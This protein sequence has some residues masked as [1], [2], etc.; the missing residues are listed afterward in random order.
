MAT[1]EDLRDEITRE[2]RV[3]N[4]RADGTVSA[5][6][7]HRRR[8]QMFLLAVVVL[9]GL[10]FTTVANDV[11]TSFRDH[12]WIDPDVARFVLIGFGVISAWYLYD[13]EQHLKR[14]SRLGRD[15]HDLD[16]ALAATMLQ[17]AFVADAT[18]A[19]HSSLDLDDVFERVVEQACR[20]VGAASASLRLAGEDGELV[21]VATQVDI[22]GGALAES[23]PSDDLLRVVGRTQEPALLNSGTVSVLCIPL[24]RDHHLIGL[25]T[26]GAG[27]ADRFNDAD[28]ALLGRFATPAANAIANAQ[29]YEAVVFLLDRGQVGP[30]LRIDEAPDAA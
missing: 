12:S 21:P 14:L 4:L 20:L 11:W 5:E 29:R 23:E 13:K 30:S 22:A 9:V 19:V 17:S 16:A 3:S 10:L 25:I 24:L 2:E 28:A 8:R 1:I 15:V 18:E 6:E 7:I 26:L 27:A